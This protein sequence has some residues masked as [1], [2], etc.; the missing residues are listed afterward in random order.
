[1]IFLHFSIFAE[2]P[3]DPIA[4]FEVLYETSVFEQRDVKSNIEVWRQIE[5]QKVKKFDR[6]LSTLAQK[7]SSED[8]GN[9]EGKKMIKVQSN[10]DKPRHIFTQIGKC[11]KWNYVLFRYQ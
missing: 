4:D 11:G 3:S 10:L 2:T 6:F 7:G 8:E 1:M 9:K 5:I